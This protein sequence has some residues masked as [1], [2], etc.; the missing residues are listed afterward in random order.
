[1]LLAGN[2]L[3]ARPNDNSGNQVGNN[4]NQGNQGSQDGGNGNNQQ[5]MNQ[6]D[7]HKNNNN[8][9]NNENNNQNNRQNNDKNKGSYIDRNQ[10][11]GDQGFDKHRVGAL[12]ES[13]YKDRHDDNWRYRHWGR[14][15]WYWV[16]AGYW[17]YWRD[18]RWVRYEEASYSYEDEPQNEQLNGP[19]YED[20][21]GFYS[22]QNGRRVYDS[23]I[24]RD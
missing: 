14:E 21:K 13:K 19:W 2:L 24:H 18:G 23:H 3:A 12:D 6:N 8:N 22:M 16:P 15:W 11:L 4:V 5:Q 7:K 9:N 10:Q 1:V 20:S 17:M